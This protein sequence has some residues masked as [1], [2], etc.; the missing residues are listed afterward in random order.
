MLITFEHRA[1]STPL[2]ERV[3]RSRSDQGGTFHSMASCNWG[4]VF[5][6]VA[7]RTSVTVRGPET[8]ATAADCP[9]DGEWFGVQFQVGTFMPLLPAGMLRDRNDGKLYIVDANKT[10]MGP[11]IALNLP[12]KI[13]ATR[14]LR[15]AFRQYALGASH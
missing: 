6:R 9:A 4:I 2:V 14:M 15:D 1:S 13:K 11:P 7:G 12:D 8:K 3:W 10:D 5:S